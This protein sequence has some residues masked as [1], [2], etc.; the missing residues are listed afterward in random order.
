MQP[1]QRTTSKV[2]AFRRG[3]D[4]THRRVIGPNWVEVYLRNVVKVQEQTVR[5]M[6]ALA[7]GNVDIGARA[8]LAKPAIVLEMRRAS[9]AATSK[10]QKTNE[11]NSPIE[12]PSLKAYRRRRRTAS[13]EAS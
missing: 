2:I 13:P 4:E 5:L 1:E 6:R 12:R 11:P 9:E 10:A 3:E 7:E 8:M